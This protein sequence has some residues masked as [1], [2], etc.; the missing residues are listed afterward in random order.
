M[1]AS[2]R[3]GHENDWPSRKIG[4]VT[5]QATKRP[6]AMPMAVP[7]AATI[8]DSERIDRRSWPRVMPTARSR[9]ISGV[10]STTDRISVLTMPNRA[11]ITARPSSAL[12]D[13]MMALKKALIRLANWLPAVTFTD[14]YCAVRSSSDRCTDGIE[15]RRR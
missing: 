10:R 5:A 15:R 4:W 1:T 2:S 8:T 14:E 11:M 12:T 3:K 9:P 7:S 13:E 6:K